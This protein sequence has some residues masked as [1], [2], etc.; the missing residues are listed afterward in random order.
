MPVAVKAIQELNKKN[1]QLESK[2]KLLEIQIS[3]YKT[4]EARLSA[5]E[6]GSTTLTEE[7]V[8]SEKK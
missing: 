4:L 8:S 7:I 3:N 2:I 6:T 5:L 1:E